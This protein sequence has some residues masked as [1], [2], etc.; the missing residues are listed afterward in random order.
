MACAS[1]N[2]VPSNQLKFLRQFPVTVIKTATGV[3]ILKTKKVIK[4]HHL[5]TALHH[6]VAISTGS[7]QL[8]SPPRTSLDYYPLRVTV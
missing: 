2:V 5:V 6:T 3:A 1:L 8:Y 4:I 7:S